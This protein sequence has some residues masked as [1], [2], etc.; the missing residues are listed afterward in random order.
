MTVFDRITIDPAR[1]NGQPC[2][3]GLRITVHRV[4]EAVAL[5]P[6]REELR[7]EYP[8][9]DDEDIRQALAYAAAMS[10]PK[11]PTPG[12]VW[13]V[14]VLVTFAL[15]T[16]LMS[17]LIGVRKQVGSDIPDQFP[18]LVVSPGQGKHPTTARIL[19]HDEL[20]SYLS[21]S[22]H[23]SFLVPEGLEGQLNGQVAS[24]M[25]PGV[26]GT[27][28]FTVRRLADGRQELKVIRNWGVEKMP[29]IDTGWYFAT[30]NGF[31]PKYYSVGTFPGF[32]LIPCVVPAFIL[33]GVAWA[34]G[35]LVFRSIK[36]RRLTRTGGLIIGR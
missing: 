31:T 33:N 26:R 34:I 14:F 29:W 30:A 19:F 35:A 32:A 6:D 10:T 5:Y 27:D 20:E 3:R 11:R 18:V 2:I 28:S 1:M 21:K 15:L 22:P 36:R 9:L 16:Y 8:E 7:R 23:T 13:V 25:R 24:Q 4:L 17:T 12:S